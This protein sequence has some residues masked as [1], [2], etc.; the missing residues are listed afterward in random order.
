ME[1]REFDSETFDRN[2]HRIMFRNGITKQKM[3]SELSG[4][5]MG[6]ISRYTNGVREPGISV[7]MKLAYVLNCSIDELVYPKQ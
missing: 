1:F 2:L 4:V 7:L 3:L 6:D 5:S